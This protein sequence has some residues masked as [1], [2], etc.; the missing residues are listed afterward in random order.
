M[1]HLDEFL[2]SRGDAYICTV[3]DV[4]SYLYGGDMQTYSSQNVLY[5]GY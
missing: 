3:L 5:G 2:D 4:D 1:V